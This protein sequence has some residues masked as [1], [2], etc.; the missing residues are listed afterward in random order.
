MLMRAFASDEITISISI[1][2][3]TLSVLTFDRISIYLCSFDMTS[4]AA[5]TL[6]PGSKPVA[7][8]AEKLLKNKLK[9]LKTEFVKLQEEMKVS[10]IVTVCCFLL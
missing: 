7:T 5:E 10:F 4:P 6:V 9:F 8:E 3:A 1:I 2:V